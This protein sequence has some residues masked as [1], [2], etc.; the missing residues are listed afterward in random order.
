MYTVKYETKSYEQYHVV[1]KHQV[2]CEETL[3][4]HAGI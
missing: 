4:T 3:Q 2:P 1:R